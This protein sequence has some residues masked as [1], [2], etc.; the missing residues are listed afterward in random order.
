MGKNHLIAFIGAASLLLASTAMSGAKTGE[1]CGPVVKLTEGGCI[2]VK[3]TQAGGPM[4]DITSANP[5]PHVDETIMGS[6]TITDKI[7]IC[8]QG[9]P[10][11]DVKWKKVAD[12]PLAK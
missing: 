8:M 12:C 6:G 11:T 10:L 1:F 3:S 7:T 4:Y 5:K 9:T 2:G